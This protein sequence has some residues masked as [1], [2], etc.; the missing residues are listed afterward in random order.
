MES[1]LKHSVEITDDGNMYKVIVESDGFIEHCYV[2]SMHL[3]DEK[4]KSLADKITQKAREAYL[5]GFDDV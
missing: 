1:G 2:S 4:V 5:Q 3:V